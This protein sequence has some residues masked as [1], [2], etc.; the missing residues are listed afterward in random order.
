VHPEGI[1]AQRDLGR[2]QSVE[3]KDRNARHI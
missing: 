3:K 2:D 1:I